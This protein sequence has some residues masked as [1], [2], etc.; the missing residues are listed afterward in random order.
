MSERHTGAFI[1]GDGSELHDQCAV[2]PQAPPANDCD[3]DH[4][5]DCR[6]LREN[7]EV[8][9]T[10]SPGSSPYEVSKLEADL[11]YFGIRGPRFLGPKLIFRTSKDVFTPPVPERNA[12]R[13]QLIPV[14]EHNELGRDDLWATVRSKIVGL[15]DQRNIKHSSVDLVRFRWVEKNVD[16]EDNGDNET[17]EANEGNEG[18]E[19]ESDDEDYEGDEEGE[20][21]SDD[22]GG[23]D[24]E[25]E[26]VDYEIPS[27]LSGPKLFAP[28]SDFDP[29]KA[30]IDPMTTALSLPIAGLKTLDNEGTMGFYF[31]DGD[32]LY[33]VTAR[34]VLFSDDEGNDS[35]T[36]IGGPK[37]EVV[38]MGGRAFTDFLTS[39]QHRIE[40]LNLVLTSLESQARTTTRRLESSGPNA[41][42]MAHG[43]AKTEAE[44]SDVRVEIEEVSKFLMNIKKEWTKPKD[45]VIGHA[46][47]A[48]SISVS[49]PSEGYTKDICVVKLDENKFS[50]NFR[51]N[52]LDLGPEK[53]RAHFIGLMLMCPRI[54]APPDFEYPADRLLKLRG[55]LSAQEMRT[56]TNKDCNGDPMRY[57]IKRGLSTLTTIGRLTG[58]E[59]HVRRY[60]TFGS[61]DSVEVAVYPY[62]QHP[63]PFSRGGDSGSIIVDARGK[64]VALLTSGT[65]STE[66]S[67]VTFGTPMHRLWEIIK[68]KYPGASLYFEGDDE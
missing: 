41:E 55:I 39:T 25:V 23:D 24:T 38:L 44:L 16:N 13:M 68:A 56:T 21:E 64:F 7:E 28:V 1:Y 46:V 18:G 51:G 10:S 34:H 36:Y 37:K 49:T 35:Y 50:Q 20:D 11:Y 61:R 58:F 19:D 66:S 45:R 67:D 4:A 29:L 53:E 33:G 15:L 6:T 65:G 59:S 60:Q 52:V 31:R 32:A 40:V 2:Y 12:R 63:G 17:N 27:V 30:V 5:S 8:S 14:Y 43:L 48:P 54:D 9:S 47:W 26:D 42:Q 22:D 57:V 3:S 62:D